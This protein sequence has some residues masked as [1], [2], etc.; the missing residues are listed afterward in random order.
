LC[1]L[2]LAE[3]WREL[4]SSVPLGLQFASHPFRF[5]VSP[6]PQAARVTL[7][8]ACL[9]P[10]DNVNRH[11]LAED[12]FPQVGLIMGMGKWGRGGAVDMLCKRIGRYMYR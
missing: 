4:P 12:R 5:S 2:Q 11:Y 3:G 1:T 9:L 8:D 10:V 7:I 6:G